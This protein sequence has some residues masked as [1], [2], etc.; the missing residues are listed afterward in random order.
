M[1]LMTPSTLPMPLAWAPNCSI[2]PRRSREWLPNPSMAETTRATISAPCLARSDISDVVLLVSEALRA[3]S[4]T[5]AA[6]S[7]MA[8]ADSV[9]RCNCLSAPRAASPTRS[10]SWSAASATVVAMASAS[11]ATPAMRSLRSRAVSSPRFTSV[12]SW[13]ISM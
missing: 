2:S 5:V 12:M 11:R 7:S 1:S 6:I 4:R 3:T 13:R 8:V 9:L 10:E